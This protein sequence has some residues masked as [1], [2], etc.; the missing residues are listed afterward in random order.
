M[1]SEEIVA[2]AT[3]AVLFVLVVVVCYLCTLYYNQRRAELRPRAPAPASPKIPKAAP[4]PEGFCGT[5]QYT[6]PYG[7]ARAGG[8]TTGA[9]PSIETDGCV[10]CRLCC[11]YNNV[12][13]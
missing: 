12:P 9:M 1:G 4:P 11:G 3:A 7:H 10:G 13:P 5:F 8:I 2:L 6:P